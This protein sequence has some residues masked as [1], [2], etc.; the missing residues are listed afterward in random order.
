MSTIGLPKV[1][2]GL[3]AHTASLLSEKR[4]QAKAA[5]ATL[6][7]IPGAESLVATI[8]DYCLSV[9][10]QEMSDIQ[11]LSSTEKSD[12]LSERKRASAELLR[13]KEHY[14]I[15]FEYAAIGLAEVTPQGNWFRVNPALCNL[16]GYTPQELGSLSFADITYPNDVEKN[17]DAMNAMIKGEF[18]SYESEKR[19]MRKDGK[20]IWARVSVSAIRDEYGSLAYQVTAVQDITAT[21]RFE[22]QLANALSSLIEVVNRVCDAHDPYTAGHQI[23]VAELSMAIAKKIGMSDEDV[24]ETYN[25]ALVHD[26]G[27][28]S[29]PAEILSKPGVLSPIEFELIKG[30]SKKGFELLTT[31]DMPG[32]VPEIVYQHHERCNGSGYPRGLTANEL[33]LQAKIIMVAD[34]VDAMMSSRPYRLGLGIDAAL[35]EIE[36][37]AGDKYC[38]EVSTACLSVFRDDGFKFSDRIKRIN[39]EW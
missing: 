39:N 10:H 14:M 28:I 22:K 30:H 12:N 25:A 23:R 9:Y 6:T 24:T 17:V 19:Y 37:C 3:Q 2:N 18:D 29:I 7:T 15:A 35:D 4:V 13:E 16:L 5:L 38:L 11:K 36:Q 27:K 26:I 1:P 31:S 21:K 8:V 32:I 20:I 34:V 33:L